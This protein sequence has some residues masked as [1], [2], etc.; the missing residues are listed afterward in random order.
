MMHVEKGEYL[1][2]PVLG[3]LR[4]IVEVCYEGTSICHE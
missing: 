4:R 3:H 1:V 2:Q